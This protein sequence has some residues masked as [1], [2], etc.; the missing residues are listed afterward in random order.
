ML[1]SGVRVVNLADGAWVILAGLD[2]PLQQLD[3][4]S[5]G[6]VAGGTSLSHWWNIIER[7]HV[8]L[9]EAHIKIYNSFGAQ[10]AK[11]HDSINMK[12]NSEATLPASQCPQSGC[13]P[14]GSH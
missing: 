5:L 4:N 7:L 10:K 8:I 2:I 13:N 9:P 6:E 1:V 12:V 11:Q 14:S 3:H